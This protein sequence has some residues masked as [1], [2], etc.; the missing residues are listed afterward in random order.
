MNYRI[1]A[2]LGGSFG[3]ANYIE[4]KEF[5]SEEEAAEYAYECA[6]EVY[7]SYEGLNG[8]P[9][10]QDIAD[11]NDL[12]LDNSEDQIIAQEMYNEEVEGWLD[13]YV[14]EDEEV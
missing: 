9:S 14:E 2:G 1:Y 10:M 12:D 4:T 13:Y 8:L 6:L 5:R 7:D 3:G 11:E